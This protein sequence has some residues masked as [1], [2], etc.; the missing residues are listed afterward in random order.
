MDK[1]FQGY[2][3]IHANGVWHGDHEK[4]LILEI[5]EDVTDAVTVA[6]KLA[7][8][9]IRDLNN[10]EAVLVTVDDLTDWEMV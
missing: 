5:V 8:T 10:Q 6:V 1:Y 2:T 3:V 4:T 9:Q 7:A